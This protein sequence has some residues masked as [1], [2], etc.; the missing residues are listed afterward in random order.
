[1]KIKDPLKVLTSQHMRKKHVY[2]AKESQRIFHSISLFVLAIASLICALILVPFLLFFSST[3]VYT[4]VL[5]VGL[6]FGFIF[7]FMIVD[8]QHLEHRHH[9]ISGIVVP[10]IAVFNIFVMMSLAEKVSNYFMLQ[11]THDPLVVATFY[12]MG[13]ILPYLFFGLV[14]YLKNR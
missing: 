4:L 13:F 11:L 2:Y 3:T 12:L 14:D 6:L 8:L 9:V 7:S 1:M 5:L 10:V